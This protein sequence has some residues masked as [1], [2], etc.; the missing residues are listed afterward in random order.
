MRVLILGGTGLISTG[1]TR[2]LLQRG[3]E[4]WHLNRGTTESEETRYVNTVIADRNDKESLVTAA[5]QMPLFDVAIDMIGFTPEQVS[6][7]IESFGSRC[8]QLIFCSTVDVYARPS[9]VYPITES[10]PKRPAPWRYA[11]DKVRCETILQRW[12]EES[13]VPLTILRPAHTYSDTGSLVHSL[14]FGTYYL[15]RLM[16]QL[17]IIVHGDGSS[18]W[19][20]AHR[21]D[22]A[23]AFANAVGNEQTFG[24]S[25]HVAAEECIT[26]NQIHERVAEGI[27]APPPHLVHIPTA[28][29]ASLDQ[30]AFITAVNLSYNNCFDQ[31]MAK[32]DLNWKYTITLKE[33]ARRVFQTLRDRNA[34]VSADDVP[35]DDQIIK[36]WTRS[37]KQLRQEVTE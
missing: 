20:S 32:S 6:A 11:Q 22:V 17:P 28:I 21:D 19:G 29:L 12:A 13:Q 9:S 16:R 37:M 26:W 27:G 24:R 34:I 4:V 36:R 10:E 1:I 14:G 7:L 2:E 33:G 23:V 5:G 8:G 31:S 30:R 3:H 18:L 25:Y 35:E 15:D